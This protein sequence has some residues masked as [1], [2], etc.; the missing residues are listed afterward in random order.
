MCC[1]SISHKNHDKNKCRREGERW[2]DMNQANFF[3]S[4]ETLSVEKEKYVSLG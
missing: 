1:K 4:I 2:A 3:L